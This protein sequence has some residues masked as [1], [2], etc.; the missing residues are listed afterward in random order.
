MNLSKA[1]SCMLFLSEILKQSTVNIGGI[2]ITI[3]SQKEL[4]FA[5]SYLHLFFKKA[6]DFF[7]LPRKLIDMRY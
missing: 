2:I 7:D 6:I 3:V 4:G 1:N 5:E